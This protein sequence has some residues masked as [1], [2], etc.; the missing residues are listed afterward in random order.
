LLTLIWEIARIKPDVVFVGGVSEWIQGKRTSTTDID[1]CVTNL[2]GLEHL[3]EIK[4][5]NT[6]SKFSKS[7]LRAGI[8]NQEYLIDIFIEKELPE[9]VEIEGIKYQTIPSL[10]QEYTRVVQAITDPVYVISKTKME[11]KL[12]NLLAQQ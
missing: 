1:I 11:N 4:Q 10:I 12:A 9:Y 7:G 6:D 2:I 5:W 3:G 8:E